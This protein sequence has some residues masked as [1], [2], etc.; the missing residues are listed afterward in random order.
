MRKTLAVLAVSAPLFAMEI[1]G[2][3]ATFPQPLYQR[4]AY[5]FEKA[6]GYK[7]NYQG[8][9]SGGGIRQITNRTVDFGASDAPLTPEELE[10]NKLLQFPTV[11]GAVV[12]T[13]NV[14]ELGKRVLN[15]DSKAVCDIYLGK[16]TKWNDPY[17]Q[18]I[19]PGVRL[20]DRD[21]VVVHRSDGSGTSFIFTTWLSQT[22]P[23]W[24]EKVG[25]G[26]AVNWPTGIGAKGNPG[27][28]NYVKRSEGGIG[29]VEYIYAKENN[30]P[31]ARIKNSAGHWVEPSPKTMQAAAA[32]A[33][34]DPSKHFYE[35]LVNQPGKDSYPIAGAT[36]ILLAKDQPERSKKATTFFRWAFEKGDNTALQ[37]HY[38]PLPKKVKEEIFKYW[39]QHGVNP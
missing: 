18:S 31:M 3:G 34:W 30:L 1:T 12:V 28:T 22:C 10:K 33:K 39:Q 5:E 20:P 8:I 17:L 24:K 7:V 4:W 35:V 2:A 14:P 36:F 9:G 15:L 11:I 27:V 32:G 38:V 19:N 16:I 29:Y 21:I 37:L 25:A 23:E 6:T 13:Y 26:T